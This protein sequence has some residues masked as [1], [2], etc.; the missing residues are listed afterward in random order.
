[1]PPIGSGIP[2]LDRHRKALDAIDQRLGDGYMREVTVKIP[3]IEHPRRPEE[4]EYLIEKIADKSIPSLRERVR[5]KVRYALDTGKEIV[6][7]FSTPQ[8]TSTK[9]GGFSQRS[10]MGG[11]GTVLPTAREGESV[12]YDANTKGTLGQNMA[13]DSPTW[14][15]LQSLNRFFLE[16]GVI[17]PN[18]TRALVNAIDPYLEKGVNV[19]PKG[20]IKTALKFVKDLDMAIL[21]GGATPATLLSQPLAKGVGAAVSPAWNYFRSTVGR[22][23]GYLAGQAAK[24]L[25]LNKLAK[26]PIGNVEWIPGIGGKGVPP[27]NNIGALFSRTFGVPESTVKLADKAKLLERSGLAVEAGEG[28][29]AI[30]TNP[31]PG[32]AGAGESVPLLSDLLPGEQKAMRAL[33]DKGYFDIPLVSDTP[34][35]AAVLEAQKKAAMD[36]AQAR[37]ARFMESKGDYSKK[38]LR[39]L[40]FDVAGPGQGAAVMKAKKLTPQLEALH[41][42]LAPTTG[43][44]ERALTEGRKVLSLGGTL[45]PE[46]NEILLRSGGPVA[47][48][49][50]LINMVSGAQ[51]ARAGELMGRARKVTDQ[52]KKLAIPRAQNEMESFFTQKGA[53]K[54][55]EGATKMEMA[56][57][58][59]VGQI[60]GRFGRYMGSKRYLDK[61][62]VASLAFQP[63]AKGLFSGLSDDASLMARGKAPSGKIEIPLGAEVAGGM[64][65]Q[66]RDVA[67]KAFIN[68]L[69]KSGRGVSDR[70]VDGWV[71]VTD[72]ALTAYGLA[73]KYV[74]PNTMRFIQS[75]LGRIRPGYFPKMAR[76]FKAAVTS[77]YPSTFLANIPSTAGQAYLSGTPVK[78]I[79]SGGATALRDMLTGGKA[80]SDK[81]VALGLKTDMP[82]MDKY[83]DLGAI[84]QEIEAGG[85][86]SAREILANYNRLLKTRSRRAG[87]TSL[88][89]RGYQANEEL[90]K[91]AQHPEYIRRGQKPI[92]AG[93]SANKS[94]YDYGDTSDVMRAV[95]S[96]LFSPAMFLTYPMKA[97]EQ[98]ARAAVANPQAIARMKMAMEALNSAAA[99][100]MNVSPDLP[101]QYARQSAQVARS[102]RGILPENWWGAKGAEALGREMMPRVIIP[103]EFMRTPELSTGKNLGATKR[104]NLYGSRGA[105]ETRMTGEGLPAMI[106]AGR[107]S[108][109]GAAYG[110]ARGVGSVGPGWNA[111]LQAYKN[112]RAVEPGGFLKGAAAPAGQVA[113][114]AVPSLAPLA[115]PIFMQAVKYALLHGAR[116]NE[117]IRYQMQQYFA[118]DFGNPYSPMA[119]NRG[120]PGATDTKQRDLLMQMLGVGFPVRAFPEQVQ[121][122]RQ[123]APYKERA[124]E[125]KK[126]VQRGRNRKIPNYQSSYNNRS[127]A[128]TQGWGEPVRSSYA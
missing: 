79:V 56:Q 16:R 18:Q 8:Y 106:G 85:A 78:R 47:S 23:G 9:F 45:P 54:L 2:E 40:A 108:P 87:L 3:L 123:R 88:A 74:E 36:R 65:T 25:G 58:E 24:R 118:Q 72:D 7:P 62:P 82:E 80:G 120:N 31:I 113:L 68:A 17:I 13:T 67:N 96:G 75:T 90:W 64:A 71:K 109:L 26:I 32:M 28:G 19:L 97:G 12:G 86:G 55:G 114:T 100:D 101:M 94:I 126:D 127:G 117:E 104:P 57:A 99:S 115:S 59:R 46:V 22:A 15:E 53:T 37:L 119:I 81:A 33:S 39:G 43:A 69:A 98:V 14:R 125:R 20:K 51:G 48:K 44:E 73:G 84:M 50:F 124:I 29:K 116:S 105:V 35:P 34:V 92:E 30:V 76:G 21:Q 42:G 77:L 41:K 49:D 52:F 6:V 110:L 95:T 61:T 83:F 103:S 102:G 91:R 70:A 107:Y 122:N 63:T 111:I 10:G 27:P 128:P 93:V 38:E 5:E 66:S 60:L 11:R 112:T 1:M 4:R 89:S 121:E